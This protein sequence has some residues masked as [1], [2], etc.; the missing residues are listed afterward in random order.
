MNGPK[1][2]SSG[3]IEKIQCYI[4]TKK[5]RSVWVFL[6]LEPLKFSQA[7]DL[8]TR[9]TPTTAITFLIVLASVPTRNLS[10][11]IGPGLDNLDGS[12]LSFHKILCLSEENLEYSHYIHIMM[13]RLVSPRGHRYNFILLRCFFSVSGNWEACVTLIYLQH[14]VTIIDNF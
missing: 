11:A 3:I 14:C 6:F 2:G 8:T 7:F 10:S 1:S 5:L 13:W 9:L 12:T 4:E